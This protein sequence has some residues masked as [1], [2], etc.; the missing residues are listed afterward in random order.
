MVTALFAFFYAL[1]SICLGYYASGKLLCHRSRILLS[2]GIA[3][4]VGAFLGPLGAVVSSVPSAIIANRNS[5]S[6]GG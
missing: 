3:Y 5:D 6:R 4:S 2:V 1:G